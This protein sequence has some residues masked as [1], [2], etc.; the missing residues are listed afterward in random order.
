MIEGKNYQFKIANHKVLGQAVNF[1]YKFAREI[2][3]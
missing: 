2:P 1:I 3:A